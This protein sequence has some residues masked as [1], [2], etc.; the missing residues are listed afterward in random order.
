MSS[1]PGSCSSENAGVGALLHS[2]A[3]SLSNCG[4]ALVGS[5]VL[6]HRSAAVCGAPLL[7]SPPPSPVKHSHLTRADAS[8][9]RIRARRGYVQPRSPELPS[10]LQRSEASASTTAPLTPGRLP[11]RHLP[12]TRRGDGFMHKPRF[13]RWPACCILSVLLYWIY[14]PLPPTQPPS[15]LQKS[16]QRDLELFRRAQRAGKV[17]VTRNNSRHMQLMYNSCI[18]PADVL[19]KVIN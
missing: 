10:L 11:P 6:S 5:G 12:R 3:Q 13:Q 9:S 2:W 15:L 4:L 18:N 16:T 8:V 7:L 17:E 19:Y 1:N 14:S